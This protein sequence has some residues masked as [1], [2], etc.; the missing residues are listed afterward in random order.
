MQANGDQIGTQEFVPETQ[1]QKR[2]EL[3]R[4]RDTDKRSSLWAESGGQ[5]TQ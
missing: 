5:V 4:L 3:L 1:G 2:P